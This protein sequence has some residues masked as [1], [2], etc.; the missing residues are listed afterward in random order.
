MSHAPVRSPDRGP[1]RLHPR[2][3]PALKGAK[4]AA[5]RSIVPAALLLAILLVSPAALGQQEDGAAKEPEITVQPLAPLTPAR[6][7]QE[8]A[9]EG[10]SSPRFKRAPFRTEGPPIYRER[11]ELPPT[12]LKAGAR[13]RKLDK[14]T[15]RSTTFELVAGEKATIDRLEIRLEACRAPADN[16]VQG[17]IAFLRIRDTRESDARPAFSG[18]MFAESPAISALDHPRYDLWVISCITS[19]TGA[20]GPSE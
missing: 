3:G 5:M 19:D 7:G 13:L 4:T 16:A 6:T 20:A 2:L 18:W 12:E 1:A 9:G 14:M 10:D 17:T 11:L 8:S 15:G